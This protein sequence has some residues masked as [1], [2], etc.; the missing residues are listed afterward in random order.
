[1]HS[2]E[3]VVSFKLDVGKS[4]AKQVASE[5]GSR[6]DSA[7]EAAAGDGGAKLDDRV[8]EVRK[9]MKKL[10]AVLRLVRRPL[11]DEYA[12]QNAYF[13]DVAARLSSARD[14]QVMVETLD[15]VLSHH[16]QT[17]D[18]KIF[19]SIRRHLVGHRSATRG[20]SGHVQQR[21][22]GAA[23]ALKEG[24]ALLDAWQLDDSG[25]DLIEPGLRKVYARGR[26]AMKH[27]AD[28]PSDENLHE[29]RKR[30]K[31]HRYHADL[32]RDI[33]PPMMQCYSAQMKQMTDLLGDDHDLAV[34]AVH[35]RN[36]PPELED[37]DAALAT[38]HELIAGRRQAL[39]SQ[40]FCLGRR[41]W[42]ESP[43][44][45]TRRWR[46]Y[47]DAASCEEAAT[48]SPPG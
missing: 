15:K 22:A 47:F 11:G 5:A 24:R 34:L 16:K 6:I 13:R 36:S 18:R 41:I 33:W 3:V 31:Y 1:M 32:L 39:Q 21:L 44:R 7:L 8:H 25:F 19:A 42:A 43:R 28:D 17:V 2:M 29:W 4:V 37:G 14:A 35:L 30:A 48:S 26:D 12:K 45:M 20:S 23:T 40:A 38:L 9:Q 46:R 27:A 10:R